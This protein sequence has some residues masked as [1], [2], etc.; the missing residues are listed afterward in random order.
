MW[1]LGRISNLDDLKCVGV[2]TEAAHKCPALFIVC[3]CSLAWLFVVMYVEVRGKYQMSSW[4]CILRGLWSETSWPKSSGCLPVVPI[5]PTLA[6][7]VHVTT[8]TF[9]VDAGGFSSD[10]PA[11]MVGLTEPPLQPCPIEDIC[12]LRFGYFG[13]LATEIS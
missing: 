6:L 5:P 7:Q 13:D 4:P 9:Y 1:F 2:C 8:L 12:I 3:V 11:W 10:L